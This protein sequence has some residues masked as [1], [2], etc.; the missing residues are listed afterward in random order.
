MACASLP[1]GHEADLI[2]AVAEGVVF[3][4]LEYL[5]S[6]DV[7]RLVVLRPRLTTQE[8]CALLS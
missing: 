5:L 4:S 2:E 6:S 3:D 1:S 7:S 8:R